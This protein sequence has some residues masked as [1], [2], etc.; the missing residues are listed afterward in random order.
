MQLAWAPS[1]VGQ[2]FDE[3]VKF[4]ASERLAPR[5]PVDDWPALVTV[6]SVSA[7]ALPRASVMKSCAPGPR[8]RL[9]TLSAVPVNDAVVGPPGV[10]MMV[11]VAGLDPALPV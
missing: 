10:A 1:V 4:V 3:M 8:V 7:L 11:R 9:P 2:L 6:N 5:V